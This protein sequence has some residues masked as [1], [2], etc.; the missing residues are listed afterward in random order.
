MMQVQQHSTMW[1]SIIYTQYFD[2][3][4]FDAIFED[5]NKKIAIRLESIK[6]Q[7]ANGQRG[8]QFSKTLDIGNRIIKVHLKTLIASQAKVP[9]LTIQRIP[10]LQSYYIY[11]KKLNREV[12][13][14]RSCYTLLGKHSDT[15][16]SDGLYSLCLDELLYLATLIKFSMHLN[17]NHFLNHCKVYSRN[18][19]QNY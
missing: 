14:N 7:P 11:L 17:Q 5:I 9:Q 4:E 16:Y 1:Y 10:I 18:H 13:S 12:D 3:S 2:I 6:I 15:H 8:S 19:T